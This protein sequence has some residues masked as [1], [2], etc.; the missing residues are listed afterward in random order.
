MRHDVTVTSSP[1]GRAWYALAGAAA[2]AVG[3]ATSFAVA[4]AMHA[5]VSPVVA[6]A[7]EVRDRTPGDLA[8]RLVHLVGHKDKPLLVTGTLIGLVVLCGLAGA[9]G[10][11]RPLAADLVFLALGALGMLAVL[12]QPHHDV[13]SV[14][15][16]IVGL[17]TW[18]IVLR[19]LTGLLAGPETDD[20]GWLAGPRRRFLAAGAGVALVG[21]LA[22]VGGRL[23]GRGRRAVEEA[24][25]L[26]RLPVT[27]GTAPAGA[28]VGV[29]GIDPWRTRNGRFY[30]ID[31]T[32]V[33]P[34][35]RPSEWEL[36]VHGMVE[37]EVRLTYHDL[38]S[39][40]LTEAWV[41]LCCV[42]N[43]VGG[44]LIGNAWWS[45]VLVR[46]VLAEAVPHRDADAVKQTSWDGWTCGTPLS[47]LTDPGR[48]ALLAIAMNGRPLPVEHGFPVR[49]V[50]PGLYGYVSATKWVVDLEVTRFDRFSAYWT[51]RGWS[52]RGPVKTQSR[53]DV[54]RGGG[55]V[56]AGLVAFGGSAWAQHIGIAKV[57]I[58]IDGG[59]W[60]DT[61]L[62]RVPN[63]DTWVQ[64][65]TTAQVE[66]G[67]HEVRVRATD[68]SGYTQTS[69]RTDVVPNGATGWDAVTFRAD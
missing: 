33:P 8:V 13:A 48:T 12:D 30:R 5:A 43:E 27:P 62:G 49:L 14:L 56:S 40:Q 54:P 28:D 31:T 65:S 35:I 32:L 57:E 60:Q 1:P 34:A 10:R 2:G 6:V 68:R 26:L 38:V 22:L 46:D 67:T 23:A 3:G 19:L 69:A 20:T 53:I 61:T 47:A 37:R 4:W 29:E 21:G 59:P 16:V 64:W 18:I 52:E 41:T 58:Q 25:R 66:P 63:A 17:V 9:L 24:R 7:N 15:A 55:H 11:I 36:R 45:G 50:V 51:D 42:S 44:D 39:R